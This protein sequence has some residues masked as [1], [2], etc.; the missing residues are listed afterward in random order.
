VKSVIPKNICNYEDFIRWLIS[1]KKDA[2]SLLEM[3]KV[4]IIPIYI[5]MLGMKELFPIEN[6][7]SAI[8]IMM[9]IVIFSSGIIYKESKKVE[10]YKDFIE[11]AKAEDTLMNRENVLIGE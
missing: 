1:E 3:E 10:F 9:M 8:G 2:E 4:I 11:V 6:M 5:A 7:L